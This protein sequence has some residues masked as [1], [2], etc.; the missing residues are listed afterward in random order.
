M[1]DD[2]GYLMTRVTKAVP[3]PFCK[4]HRLAVFSWRSD[5]H[6]VLCLRKTCDTAG[7]KRRTI[8]GAV[9]AWDRRP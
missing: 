1:I 9:A 3:C 5:E 2:E 6:W 7:P 4:G 8:A